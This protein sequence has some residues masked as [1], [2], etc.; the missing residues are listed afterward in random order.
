MKKKINIKAVIGIASPESQKDV[1]EVTAPIA[2]SSSDSIVD[3]I[4]V[5]LP[6]DILLFC[7]SFIEA[8][9]EKGDKVIRYINT[10]PASDLISIL[11]REIF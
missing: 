8:N 1:A 9:P 3:K 7:L 11:S 2:T 10:V 4:N 6:K 5:P